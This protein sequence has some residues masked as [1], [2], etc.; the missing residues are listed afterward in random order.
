MKKEYENG[1]EGKK[2]I[3]TAGKGVCKKDK[4]MI[5][6]TARSAEIVL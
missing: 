4:E 6:E 1:S 3:D 5:V 2:S